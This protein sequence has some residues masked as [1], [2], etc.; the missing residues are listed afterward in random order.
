MWQWDE[1]RHIGQWNWSK[2]PEINLY[3]FSLLIFTSM[4]RLFSEE[5]KV[6]FQ[7][8]VLGKGIQKNEF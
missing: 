2:S 3:V 5:R 4:P 7:Q 6:I 8:S 1:D